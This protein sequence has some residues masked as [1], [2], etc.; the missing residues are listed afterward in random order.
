MYQKLYRPF[1]L[2]LAFIM[3][4]SLACSIGGTKATEAP[5]PTATVKVVEPTTPPEVKEPTNTPEPTGPKP[6]GSLDE[7][8][9]AVIQVQ[10]EGTFADPEAG[11]LV[12]AAGRGSGFII[13][14]SGLAVTNNHVVTGAA[15]LKVWV[16]GDTKKVYNARILGASECSDLAVI[17]LEGDGFPF[18]EWNPSA[19]KVGLE[20]YAAGFPL[21]EP[22]FT[23][24][25]G[26][27]SKSATSGETGW[28]SVDSV[29]MHD[30]TINPGNSG[31]PLVDKDAKVVGIN[32]AGNQADQYFAIAYAEAKKVLDELKQGKDVTSVGVNG[33]AIASPDGTI[34]G[35]WVASVKSGSP[36]DKAG[37]KPGDVI[38]HMESFQL[39]T[40]GTMADYCD[41]LRTHAPTDTLSV[42]VLRLGTNEW[43][44][45]QFNGR[46][47]EVTGNF[48]TEALGGDVQD[49][50]T[51]YDEYI[52]VS[53]DSGA[54]Q[55]DVPSG[56]SDFDGSYWEEVWTID[57]V[58][59]PFTAAAIT[60]SPN[61]DAYNN[62]WET[63]GLFFTASTEWAN[64]GG[65]VNLLDGVRGWYENDCE[66]NSDYAVYSDALYEGKYAV[67]ENCG[68]TGN[69]VVVVAARPID[70]PT[71][72]L[73]LVE[74]KVTSDAD[75]EALDRILQTFEVV[76]TLP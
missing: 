66:L 11:W 40:D 58:E 4:V 12:N 22:E 20:V 21:G 32:Y 35:I 61:I 67:W 51:T 42:T 25:K 39:S 60:A 69:K 17:D 53:D 10:S 43:L 33:S 37:I 70:Y 52:T 30:A 41:I 76:G 7:L 8:Q 62:G 2:A 28:S 68:G 5:Q 16:G 56:W 65:F 24:T 74:V 1:A 75:L 73:I 23:L 63:P 14:P 15:L 36:A 59:N 55:V 57:G 18:V 49:T 3:L 64:L 31:G 29:L 13:D 9:S 45:G 71:A 46:K 38:T 26:I 47:L 54:I 6:V 44:E 34:T 72:F 19:P 48:F 27:I 50:G